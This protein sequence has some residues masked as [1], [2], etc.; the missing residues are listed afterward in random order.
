MMLLVS[1]MGKAFIILQIVPG[2][3]YLGYLPWLITSVFR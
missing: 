2:I 1:V 3:D